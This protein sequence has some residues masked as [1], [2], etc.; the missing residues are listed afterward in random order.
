MRLSKLGERLSVHTG[1]GQL[2]RDLG[3]ALRSDREL[4]MLGG[5]NPAQIPEVMDVFRQRLE[6]MSRTPETLS[7]VMGVYDGPSGDSEFNNSVARLL[8]REFGWPVTG[9]NIAVTNGSQSAFFYLFNL[10]AGTGTDGVKRRVFLPMAP[11]YIGY[12][13]QGLESDLFVSRRPDI[14]LLP[15]QR[16]KYRLPFTAADA[17][18]DMAAICV[19]RPTNPTGNVLTEDELAVLV[20]MAGRND[21]PLFI[22]N[23]YGTPFPDIIFKDA[24]PVYNEHTV[25][26]MS[27]SKLGLPGVRTGIVVASEAII[28]A[29]SAVNAVVSLAPSSFGPALVKP[30][31]D[32]GEIVRLSRDVIRP[33]YSDRANQV[34][35]WLREAVRDTPCRVHAMEGAF[36]AWLWCEGLPI[37]S[38]E[39][40]RRLYERGVLVVSGHYFFPGLAEPWEHQDECIRINYSQDPAAVREGLRIIGEEVKR[41]YEA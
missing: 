38:E 8:K 4:I 10:F 24:M 19:S 20:D 2:M 6:E 18:A 7:R 15:D 25:V 16:F 14:E 30:L 37:R 33:Y 21:V 22:D 32:S 11:E 27:L 5:G 35:A 36:F 23:A 3:E 13:D 39:L 9:R 40:Y 41:A 17:P 12:A 29:V 31:F 34:S 28:E 1:T 26:C